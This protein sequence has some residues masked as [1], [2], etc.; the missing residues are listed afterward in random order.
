MTSKQITNV[1]QAEASM[2]GVRHRSAWGDVKSKALTSW[3][4]ASAATLVSRWRATY[5]DAGGT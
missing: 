5:T 4:R 1:I 3:L 2:L